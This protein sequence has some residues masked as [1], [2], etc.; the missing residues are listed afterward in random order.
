MVHAACFQVRILFNA[1]AFRAV[2]VVVTDP[3]LL[4]RVFEFPVRHEGGIGLLR[5]LVHLAC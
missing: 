1:V 3:S 2:S 4:C 5:P